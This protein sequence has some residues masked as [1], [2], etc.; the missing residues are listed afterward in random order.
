MKRI[1]VYS[2]PSCPQCTAT[3]KKLAKHGVPFEELDAREHVPYL[4][5]LGYRGAPVVM[6]SEG[7]DITPV[8]H[9]SGYRPERVAA[10]ADTPAPA[11]Q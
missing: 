1:T 5:S 8:D 10:L 11:E 3:K 6:V 4:K 7:D 2:K 9:W